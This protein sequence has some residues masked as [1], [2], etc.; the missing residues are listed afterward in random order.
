MYKQYKG[1]AGVKGGKGKVP[2]GRK[3]DACTVASTSL[4][5]TA[6]SA[7]Q[8]NN[9]ALFTTAVSAMQCNNNALFTTAVS[10]MQCN[11]NA[12]FTT[13]VS[14]MQCNNNAARLVSAGAGCWL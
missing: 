12:L 7:M 9:N 5:T 2:A 10:A 13:A 3:G 14:A 6:V 8:C 11:N 1:T 4:F